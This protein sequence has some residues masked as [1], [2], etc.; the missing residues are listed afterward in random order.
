MPDTS[1]FEQR[2][3]KN[4]VKR[5]AA[6]TTVERLRDELATLLAEGR[7]ARIPVAVMARA[8]GISRETTHKLLRRQEGR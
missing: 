8:A 7:A 1:R 3:A 4:R 5:K 6:E 2:L